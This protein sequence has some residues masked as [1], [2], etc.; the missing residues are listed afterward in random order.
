MSS[1]SRAATARE[2]YLARAI[3]G[4]QLT[5]AVVEVDA[6]AELPEHSRAALSQAYRLRLTSVIS[7]E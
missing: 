5:L 3:H 1:V 6:G 2:G 7:G 4:K